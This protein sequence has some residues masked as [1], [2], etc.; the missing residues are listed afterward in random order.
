MKL[1][2]YPVEVD[3][4]ELEGG[5]CVLRLF[6][7]ATDGKRV[8]VIDEHFEPYFYVL[9]EENI[10]LAKLAANIRNLRLL[11]EKH[12]AYVTRVEI[13][14]KK[15][16]GKSMPALQVYVNS[17]HDVPSLRSEVK[18]IRGVAS[19][20]E[21]DIQ[22]YRRYLIDKGIIPLFLCEVE[23]EEIES[24]LQVDL[25]IKAHKI[26]Q[27]A[28]TEQVIKNPRILSF[29]IEVYT[30]ASVRALDVAR[31]QIL[32]VALH[33]EDF[34]KV[35]TWKQFSQPKAY[36][37]FVKDEASLIM[38]FQELIAEY[39]PDYLVGYF[40][41]GFDFPYL[42]GRADK[43]GIKLRLGLDGSSVKIRNRNGMISAK[44]KGIAHIDIL[45][46]LQRA[47]SEQLDVDA[48]DLDSVAK[49]LLGEGKHQVAIEKMGYVWDNEPEKLREYCEYNLTDARIAYRLV[50]IMLPQMNEFTKLIGQ[51]P[52][53]ICR[54]TYGQLVEWYLIRHAYSLGEICPNRPKYDEMMKRR[55]KSYEGAFVFQPEAGIYKE[56]AVFDFRSLY[57]S[58]ITAHNICPTTLTKAGKNARKAPVI[59]IGNKKLQ[60][61]FRYDIDGF[62]PSLLKEILQRRKRIKE[63]MKSS[64]KSD[65]VLEARQYGLKILAN[66]F[67]GYLG[68]SGARWYSLECASSITA[69][70]RSYIRDV[71]SKAEKQKFKV[72]YSDTDSTFVSLG[73]EKS[74]RD[75]LD[76]MK[77]INLELPSLMEL[78]LQ[79]FYPW[80]LFVMKKSGLKG[81]KKKYALIDDN[82]K[83]KVVGF[84]TI[85]GDWS[86]IAKEVQKKVI[87]IVLIEHNKDSALEYVRGIIK[88]IR[89]HSLPVDKMVIQKKLRKPL[90]DYQAVG[91]HVAVAKRLVAEG[92]P[93]GPGTVISYVVQEGK[94]SIGEKALL[95]EEASS[96]DS[97]Y[98]INRQVIPAVSQIMEVLGYDKNVLEDVDQ[99][100]LGE[101]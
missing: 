98:Y 74:R 50:E 101:F 54:M 11:H 25:V 24:P 39:K 6:G 65:P 17:P 83:I 94:G 12:S 82:L 34:S 93:A 21:A 84:E 42:H 81:A 55:M 28:G 13:V 27:A 33:G 61:A 29:D 18:R 48:Y 71:I 49:V 14:E 20:Q 32:M 80:G 60:Y 38:R 77:S 92:L 58:I 7:R 78:E 22:F 4:Q 67:Y 10:D 35:I 91:P 86:V 3:V 96:Y 95:P 56:V 70:A 19:S 99:S 51:I 88:Q 23:G 36:V 16:L 53:D 41:D 72:I 69:Y 30:A 100:K 90:E 52:Y 75:A 46:F 8:C 66:S 9:P 47:M 2:F 40:T 44:I 1:S 43:Y 85:R 87:E 57:P 5:R 97:E 37:E 89:N 31:D 62:I 45:K 26:S 15:F 73:D 76:F 68:F 63:I 64:E 79:G 59:E